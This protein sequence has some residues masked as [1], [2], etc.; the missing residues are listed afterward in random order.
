[1]KAIGPLLAARSLGKTFASNTVLQGVT[2]EVRPG[3]I[4]GVLGQNGSGKST[5]VKVL[6]GVYEGDAGGTI[7]LAVGTA[8]HFIHQDL[9]LV[10]QLSTIENLDLDRPLVATDFGPARRKAERARAQEL[11]AR[12]GASFDVD[13]A[14]GRLS[15]AERTIVAIAR[16]VSGWENPRQILVLD[17]PTA[18]LHGLE[19]DRLLATVRQLAAS[20]AGV[21][22]ITHRL[23]EVFALA[24]RAIFLRDGRLIAERDVTEL[25]ESE[26]VEL[27][28]GG[29]VDGPPRT[30]PSQAGHPVLKVSGLVG[31]GCVG[32]ELEAGAG[33]I[34]GIAGLLG[35]GREHV[36]QAVF[37]AVSTTAGAVEVTGKR[38][39]R[40]SV[41][42][43]M[44]A[45]VGLVP[46]DRHAHAIV[47]SM[48]VRE[49]LTLAWLR[50]FRRWLGW[51]SRPAEDHTVAGWID[52]LAVRPGQHTPRIGLLSGGNQQ[53]VILAR[54]LQRDPKVL[55]LEEPT[56]GV[57]V[58]AKAAIYRIIAA[59]A[60][61]GTA[62][63]VASSDSRE[64]VELCDRVV[65]LRDGTSAAELSGQAL[66]EAAILTHSL[67]FD[68]SAER[69]AQ[70][71]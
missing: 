53:K 43:A 12:F 18:A 42:A 15:P 33:E 6:A 1:M 5:L 29:S 66:T 40:G 27:I 9:G 65:V 62:V 41:K 54:W 51:V 23:D 50:P 67:G 49:N 70:H 71:A 57:D 22:F 4:V 7:E 10:S 38:L 46:G 14:V 25:T 55:L 26:L 28:A 17:E 61:R 24:D 63:V 21:L 45:G 48:D 11:I 58:G 44:A 47:G 60:E 39:R 34:V 37:G 36:L 59:A 13:M 16:A 35:S 20:G 52:R 68:A 31:G 2:I 32:F 3:E 64:L 19:V 30:R 56:Q 69:E 8:L